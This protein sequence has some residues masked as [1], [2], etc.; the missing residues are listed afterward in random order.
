[1]HSRNDCQFWLFLVALAALASFP[2]LTACGGPPGPEVAHIRRAVGAEW[3]CS[4]IA[5]GS[6]GTC[7][8]CVSACAYLETDTSLKLGV[9]V[10]DPASEYLCSIDVTVK[11]GTTTLFT[12]QL[13]IGAVDLSVEAFHTDDAQVVSGDS[14]ASITVEGTGTFGASCP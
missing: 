12:G 11:Q 5:G 9:S 10:D 1:M 4:A 7:P 8:D 3:T 6:P 2:T 14:D 13:G